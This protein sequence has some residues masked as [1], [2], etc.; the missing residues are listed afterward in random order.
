M[1]Q[2]AHFAVLHAGNEARHAEYEARHAEYEA[3]HAEHAAEHAAWRSEHD[4]DI[5]EIRRLLLRSSALQVQSRPWRRKALK[6]RK[7]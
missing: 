4:A 1:E 5:K 7:F 2:Q 6:R 3:R